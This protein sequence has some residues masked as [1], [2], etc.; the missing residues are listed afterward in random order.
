[1]L[2]ISKSKKKLNRLPTRTLTDAAIK[3]RYDLQEYIYNSPDAFCQELGQDLT[4][5]GKEVRPSP[6]VADRIDLLALDRQGNSVIIELKRGNDKLQLLQ[7]VS[8]AAM[9]AKWSG[10]EILDGPEKKSPRR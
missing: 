8:Y 9:M 4:I 10:K 3:E 1:M 7:A 6:E 5:I 2:R